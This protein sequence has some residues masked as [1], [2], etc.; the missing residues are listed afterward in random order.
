MHIR[1][2]LL[3]FFGLVLAVTLTLVAFKQPASADI[4][5]Q[6]F[7]DGSHRVGIDVAP[8]T[9]FAE[10][11]DGICAL[12]ITD[13]DGAQRTPT[14]RG[15][16]IV[17][18]TES[19]TL[20]QV[21]G[22]GEWRPHETLGRKHLL[23]A[24][25]EGLYEVG[26]DIAPGIYIA[27]RNQGRCLWF[28]RTDFTYQ[29][30]YDGLVTWWRVG[31]PIVE[32]KIGDGGFY[33][34]RCGKWQIREGGRSAEPISEFSDG[35]YV[36]GVDI[37]PGDYM[38]NSGDNVCRWFRNSPFS[39]SVPDFSGGYQSI[40]RQIATI[41]SSDTG[42][43]SDGCGPWTR[44]DRDDMHAEPEPT[45]GAGTFAVGID[46]QPGVYIA[47]ALEGR[48]CRWFLLGGFT[49]RD[50]DIMNGG[51][52]IL[53][54]IVEL[55]DA[56]VGFR[57]IDCSPWTQFVSNVD[58]DPAETFGDGE[59][60]VNLH[61]S[62][63]IYASPGSER[64]RCSWRRFTAFGTGLG[65]NPAVR[66]PTGRNIAEIETTD[67]VF[68]SYGCGGWEPFAPDVQSKMLTTFERGTWAVNTEISSGT[69]IAKEPDG[70]VCYWSRLSAFT[71]EPED[72]TVSEQS[73]GQSVTTIHSHDVG[74]YSDGC[75]FWTLVT[76]E[77]PVSAAEI[78]DSFE[79][80]VYIVNQDVGQ[81][82]YIADV[83]EDS[84]CFWSRLS[85]FD[86]DA[87][88]RINDYRSTGQAIATILESDKGFR[89]RGCGTWSRLEV[90]DA[91]GSDPASPVD[92][93]AQPTHRPSEAD[94]DDIVTSMF[95]DGTYRVGVDISPGTYIATSTGNA[96]C[97]WRRLSDF[98]WTSGNIVEVIAAGPKIVTILPTDIGFAS[99]WCG[100][101]TLLDTHQPSQSEMP[102]TFSDGSYFVGVHIEPGTYYT[103]P[104]R[105]GSCRWRIADDF[106]GDA[107][108][109]VIA[110]KT[111]D[112]WIVTIEPSDVGFFTYGCGIWRKV[113]DRLPLAP[114]DTFDDGV[115]RV[116]A[117]IVPGNYVAKVP[118][119]P[120]IDGRPRPTCRWQ[121]VA[122]FRYAESDVIE[123]S[124]EFSVAP[125]GATARR[126]FGIIRIEV[127]IDPADSGFASS[128]CGRWH[129]AD[130]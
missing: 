67:A 49:G 51:S 1:A 30:G 127:T 118:T 86:G 8:G 91:P 47:D 85:G 16:A 61:I 112:R 79:D 106:T 59:H 101:W 38:A 18:I 72:Y 21:A 48:Q 58:V 55:P 108:A 41:L 125:I 105:L 75:G 103:V 117:E 111:N 130:G 54:G 60:V 7:T 84:N 13:I 34:I 102:R 10:F 53:R 29:P 35:S 119:A 66:I 2:K 22:C 80:G 124:D 90:H 95:S 19:D 123:S 15:R 99:A 94:E 11:E 100:E 122:G 40:G 116:D 56:P 128:G 37:E 83:V 45:I 93:K 110:G 69:Y 27:D 28:K 9:Y 129:R 77:S 3:P 24:F 97:R 6:V 89:S 63:G 42:F 44:F 52:G 114:Y 104:R 23:N 87:F 62:P 26:V 14:F 68:K 113:E 64:G 31:E 57:S 74:F 88:S 81:G 98:T 39:V 36:V 121:R 82:T 115:Y 76:T 43:Y 12:S 65:T 96:T 33:S 120:F 4:A 32:L 70:S 5:S 50:E 109:A 92:S 73:V 126:S 71:G 107:A 20:L 25:G 46:V 17:T 78:P